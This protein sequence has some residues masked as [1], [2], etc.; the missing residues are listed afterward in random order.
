MIRRPPRSTRTNTLFPY[1]PPFRSPA[2][3]DRTVGPLSGG[4]WPQR[5]RADAG[6]RRALA[7]R[8]VRMRDR[9]LPHRGAI[10]D[11][12]DAAHRRLSPQCRRAVA[13]PARKSVVWGKS[14][15]VRLSVGGRR[16]IKKKKK[17]K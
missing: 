14:V 15:S 12:G 1:T 10:Y 8:C 13:R 5:R 11:A 3:Q 6:D 17:N 16:T 4:L 9:G 2:D 7:R